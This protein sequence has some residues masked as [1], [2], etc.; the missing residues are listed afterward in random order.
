MKG[1]IATGEPV[2]RPDL[3][4]GIEDIMK[5]MDY[6]N[7]RELEKRLLSTDALDAKY[8]AGQ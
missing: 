8:G 1:V 4:V 2:D 7:M 3:A 5:L 6:D